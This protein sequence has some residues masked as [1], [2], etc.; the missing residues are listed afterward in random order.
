MC[1][2]LCRMKHYSMYTQKVCP[3]PFALCQNLA[4]LP[5]WHQRGLSSSH[6]TLLVSEPSCPSEA[7]PAKSF[8]ALVF[9]VRQHMCLCPSVQRLFHFRNVV[10]A[11]YRSTKSLV[12]VHIHQDHIFSLSPLRV[13]FCFHVRCVSTLLPFSSAGLHCCCTVRRNTELQVNQKPLQQENKTAASLFLSICQFICQ[14]SHNSSRV[15]QECRKAATA[16]VVDKKR[17]EGGLS[18]L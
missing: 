12:F 9:G 6:N 8:Q 2:V 18:G 4:V 3:P 17:G 14:S 11:C 5:P 13:H 16:E 10:S 7:S 1:T 15:E